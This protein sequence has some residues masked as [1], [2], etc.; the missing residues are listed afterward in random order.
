MAGS[1]DALAQLQSAQSSALTPEQATTQANQANGV[2]AAQQTVTGLRGAIQH[3]TSLLN[4]VAPSVYGRTGGSLVT[5][6][7]ATR[8]IG[9]EQ[10]PIQTDLA[11]DTQDYTD[12]NADAQTAEQKAEKQ[13]DDT[14]TGQNSRLSYLQGIYQDMY[15]Q[16]QDQAKA[17]EQ[18]KQDAEQQREFNATPHGTAANSGLDLSGLEQLLSGGTS[19]SSAAGSYTRDSV[20]GYAVKDASGKPITLAQY[21]DTNGGGV[22]DVLSLLAKGSAGDQKT[23][24]IISS[25]LK[26]NKFGTGNQIST[27]L[28][29][30]YPQIFGG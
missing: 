21:I 7:Q 20:G 9:N 23:A 1:A 2:D 18:A 6:A 11:K 28:S 29:R 10:A 24:Q 26:S 19:G 4:N 27:N 8:Q 5:D 15:G 17:A 22:S 25:G 16:E 12:A 3:T 30:L 14:I 13:A